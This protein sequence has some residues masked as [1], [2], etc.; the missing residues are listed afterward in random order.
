MLDIARSER[1]R[2]ILKVTHGH[3]QVLLDQDTRGLMIRDI[4]S[5]NTER[6]QQRAGWHYQGRI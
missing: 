6:Y 5:T 1:T 4:T 2:V 3:R